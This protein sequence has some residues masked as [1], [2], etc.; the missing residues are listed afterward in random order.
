MAIQRMMTCARRAA[1]R[2]G[3]PDC[4]AP[5][6]PKKVSRRIG[7]RISA[8]VLSAALGCGAVPT[9][10]ANWVVTPSIAL[11]ETLTDNVNLQ[12]ADSA[13]GDLVTQLTPTLS[14]SGIGAHASLTGFLSAPILLYARTGS[15]NNYVYPLANVVGNVEAVDKFFYVEGAALVSQQFLTPFGAQPVSLASATNNRYTASSYRISPYIKGTT[16]GNVQY[17]LRNNSYW[18]TLNGSPIATDNSFTSEWLG[19][20]DSPVAPLGWSADFDLTDVKFQNQASQQTNLG[21]VGPRYAYDAQLQFHADIG[22]E[23][24]HYPFTSYR[25]YIYGVGVEW[26]PTERTSVTANWEHRFFDASYLFSFNHRTPLSVWSLNA[27]RNITS[28]PQQLASL[29]AG[30]VQ[31]LLNLLFLSRIPDPVQRQTTINALIQDQGLPANLANP[32]TLYTQQIVLQET[33]S[34]T[35][36]LLGARNSIYATVFYLH[37]E[38][39]AGSGTALPPVLAIGALND[40]TQQGINVVWTHNLT[41]SVTMNLTTTAL[42]TTANAPFSATT[43]QGNVTLT[44]TTPL[45]ARTTVFA[46]ARYQMLRANFQEGYNE[47]ALF[48]GLNYLFK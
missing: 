39:I 26:H 28:Y 7:S 27:S 43:N 8:L 15:E 5:A 19:K 33:A 21:R 6:D 31:G 44:V 32:V 25:G 3:L 12:P 17:E 9:G 20:V 1:A 30:N 36:G 38:P 11:Q 46:G 24:N 18:T 4:A 13:K 37:Q 35:V 40:N 23:D 42:R 2:P 45:S 34:A 22:Y 29:P 48:A 47:A 10:A 14:F 16:T 41:P